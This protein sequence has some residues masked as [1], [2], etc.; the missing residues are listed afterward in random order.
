MEGA[1]GLYYYCKGIAHNCNRDGPITKFFLII[2]DAQNTSQREKATTEESPT[3]ITGSAMNIQQSA[4][5]A[6]LTS[7]LVV[8][9]PYWAV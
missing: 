4:W 8:I 7:L 5:L 6:K 1:Y 2:E 3:Q 9:V